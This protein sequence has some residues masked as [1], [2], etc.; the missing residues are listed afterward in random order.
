M[1][2]RTPSSALLTESTGKI[3]KV[4]KKKKIAKAETATATATRRSH[5]LQG[6]PPPPLDLKT[7]A[8][9]T[10]PSVNVVANVPAPSSSN[11]TKKSRKTVPAPV[12]IPPPPP[13]EPTTVVSPPFSNA[14]MA[15]R[16]ISEAE[17]YVEKAERFE[18][19]AHLSMDDADG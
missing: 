5:R 8:A 3:A 7:V 13:T 14:Y 16:Y 2:R 18:R 9:I 10:K 11:I 15:K 19:L 4:A 12:V 17:E 6:I 1:G